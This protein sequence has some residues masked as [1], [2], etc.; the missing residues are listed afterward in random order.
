[1]ELGCRARRACPVGQGWR[2]APAQAEFH[3]LP[4][5]RNALARLRSK[6]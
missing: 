5:R 2:Y 1:M 6:I 4:F 3:M